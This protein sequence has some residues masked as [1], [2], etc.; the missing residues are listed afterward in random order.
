MAVIKS[1][2]GMYELVE[3]KKEE[4]SYVNTR[5]ITGWVVRIAETG[6]EILSFKGIRTQTPSSEKKEGVE[7]V[8]FSPDRKEVVIRHYDGKVEKHELPVKFSLSTD[9]STLVLE[10]KSGRIEKVERKQKG[11]AGKEPIGEEKGGKKGERKAEE[12]SHEEGKRIEE[13]EGK[14]KGRKKSSK[15]SGQ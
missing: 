14:R 12:E 6:D 8:A 10:Y 4:G 5:I 9:K 13:G 11:M 1:P 7:M 2:D 15:K 3:S